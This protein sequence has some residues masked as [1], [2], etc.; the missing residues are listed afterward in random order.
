MVREISNFMQTVHPHLK[1]F[2]ALASSS[3]LV[4]HGQAELLFIHRLFTS[5]VVV[6]LM[7]FLCKTTDPTKLQRYEN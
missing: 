1:G 7:V 2:D 4:S 5:T 3:V 6:V